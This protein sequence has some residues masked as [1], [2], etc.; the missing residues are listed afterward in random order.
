VAKDEAEA[1]KWFLLAGAQGNTVAK[2][3]Y[4]DLEKTLTPSQREEGQRLA[5]E[6][7]PK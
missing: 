2:E 6:F 3:R 4:S 1:Y 7:K 5:R